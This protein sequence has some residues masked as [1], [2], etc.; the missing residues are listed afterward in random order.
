MRQIDVICFG[1]ND[2]WYHNRDHLDIQMLSR[3]ARYGKAVYINSIVM[4]K[5]NITQNRNFTRK[6][7]RKAKSIL[8]GLKRTEKGFW[9]YSPFSLPV[10]HIAWA[11][12]MNERLLLLQ[13]WLMKLRVG[14]QKPVVW[15]ACPAACDVAI[16]IKKQRLIYQRSDRFE[17]YPNVDA[18][19]I[20]YYDRKL[21]AKADLTVFVNSSM[22]EQERAQCKKAVY[23]DQGVD[24]DMFASAERI[25]T[26]PDEMREMKKPIVGFFGGIDD[27]TSDIGLLEKVT[28]LLG[29]IT[30]AFVGNASSD[31]SQ[32]SSKDNVLMLGK[33]PYEQ[34]PHYGK[35]F[36]VA[37]L[38]WRNNR[39][40][41]TCNPIKLKEYLALGKPVVSTPFPELRKYRDVVYEAKTPEEFAGCIKKALAENGPQ[42]IAARRKRVHL[43]TWDNK[44]QLV[45]DELFGKEAN[46]E[47]SN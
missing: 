10:H 39:W 16:K 8:R 13:V 28:E 2:W 7:I 19:T 26:V 14:I 24:Y 41:E 12:R 22:Y 30:F 42:R 47:K 20:R 32:L 43:A 1:G 9:V 3:F 11:R 34:I 23:I 6:L 36:D 45:I 18:E 38:P 35:C 46:S 27:H 5:P 17:E 33:K 37:I 29:E 31:C 25:E 40:I 44:M 15:V 4:Q 21:K